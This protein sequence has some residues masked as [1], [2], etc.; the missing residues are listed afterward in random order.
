MCHITQVLI[1]GGFASSPY[2][3]VWKSICKSVI[4]V[5][6]VIYHRKIFHSIITYRCKICF[7]NNRNVPAF[8]ITSCAGMCPCC[9]EG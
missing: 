1:V 5:R 9:I 3:Q 4:A 8:S 2:L 7:V 6:Y